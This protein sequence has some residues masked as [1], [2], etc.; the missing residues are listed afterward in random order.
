LA[1]ADVFVLCSLWEGLPR[2]LVEA[3]KTGRACVCYATDGVTDIL[4]DGV[5]GFVVPQGNISALARRVLELL[6]DGELRRRLGSKAA[7]SIGLEF[8][9]DEMVRAQE[10][11]Y[12]SLLARHG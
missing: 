3:M 2:A 12:E 11:L 8:D 1:C 6:K 5:N 7:G 4:E 9:I 10:R